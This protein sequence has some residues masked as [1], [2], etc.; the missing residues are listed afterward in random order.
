MI[1]PMRTITFGMT[2]HDKQGQERGEEA[3][4]LQNSSKATENGL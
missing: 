3:E 1:A 4:Q 2:G